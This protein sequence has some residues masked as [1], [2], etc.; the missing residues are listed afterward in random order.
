MPL[1]ALLLI[2]GGLLSGLL[3]VAFVRRSG[4]TLAGMPGIYVNGPQSAFEASQRSVEYNR[5]AA[6]PTWTLMS[7]GRIAAGVWLGLWLFVFSASVPAI[8]IYRTWVESGK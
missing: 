7:I 4:E 3:F 6:P 1:A 8:I 2:L 5:P